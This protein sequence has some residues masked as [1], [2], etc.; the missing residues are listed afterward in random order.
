MYD[1]GLMYVEHALRK[2]LDEQRLVTRASAR[3]GIFRSLPVTER[4]RCGLYRPY[5][6]CEP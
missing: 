6:M 5:R 4:V 1:A 2:S 3:G